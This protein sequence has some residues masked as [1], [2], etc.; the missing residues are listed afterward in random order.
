MSV[1]ANKQ[2]VLDT[3]GA[4]TKGDID[5]FMS[6]LADDVTWTFF[7]SHRF[8]GTFRGK[9]KSSSP[10]CSRRS[11]RCWPTA[12]RCTSTPRPRKVSGW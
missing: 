4:V 6:R 10:S 7:G 9:R 1:E 2:L 8:A 5:G 11:A 3:W 12:S